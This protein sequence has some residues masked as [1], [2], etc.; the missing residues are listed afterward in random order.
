MKKLYRNGDWHFV[1]VKEEIKG[2]LIKHKG[3]FTFATGEATNHHHVMEVENA[4]DM[5]LIKMPDGSYLV[6][7]KKEATIKHPEHSLKTDLK[8]APGTYRVIQRREKD[9]FTLS[10][11][12]VID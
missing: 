3:S 4:E 5:E 12:K 7:F 8:V 6:N 10:T 11:R 1:P 2:E 9:W